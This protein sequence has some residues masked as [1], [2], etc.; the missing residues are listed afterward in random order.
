MMIRVMHGGSLPARM[1]IPD[2]D[3]PAD[4]S[5]EAAEVREVT[6]LAGQIHPDLAAPAAV[7]R[8]PIQF[9]GTE[10]YLAGEDAPFWNSFHPFLVL[11]RE[12]D[13]SLT[14]YTDDRNSQTAIKLQTNY[15]DVLHKQAALTTTG[16]QWPSGCTTSRLGAPSGNGAVEKTSGGIYYAALAISYGLFGRQNAI[17]VGIANSNFTALASPITPLG[18]PAVPSTLTSIDVNGD[19]KPDLIVVSANQNTGLATLSVFFGNGD[20]TYQQPRADYATQLITGSVTVADVNNDSHPDLIMVGSPASGNPASPALQVFLNDTH[21]A[22][23][24][25]INGPAIPGLEQVAVVAKFNS[26]ANPDIA[27]NGGYILLGDGTGHFTLKSGIQFSAADSLIAGDLNHD[28]KIDI[29]TISGFHYMVGIFLGNNDGTFTAGQQYASI[30]G[31]FN[32]GMSDLDGDGNQDLIAGFSDPNG[33]GPGSGS[34]S[35]VYF[36]LGRGDGTFAGAPLYTT[37]NSN[38]AMTGPS[39]ALADLDGDTK[40]DLITTTSAA[41][42]LSLFTLL[43]KGDGSFTPAT[44]PPINAFNVSI[45]PPLVVAGDL[46]GNTKNDVIVGITTQNSP[47]QGELVVFLGNGNDTF[48]TEKDTSLSSGIGAMILGDFNNDKKPDLI[49][50]GVVSIDQQNS[51][52]AG[53]LFFLAGAGTGSF[54]APTSIANP[55]NAAALASFDFDGDQNLD[56]VVGD[57]GSTNSNA[58][59]A[60]SVKVYLGNGNGSFQAPKTLNAPVFAQAI[61]TADVN[62]DSN[63]DIVVLSAPNFSG[64][65]PFV[66][67]VYVFMG[68]GHGSFGSAIT[69]TLDEFATGLQVGDLNADGFPDLA[70]TSCCGFA[71]SEVWSGNGDGTFNGPNELP[72]GLS[73]SFPVLANLNGDSKPD[74]LVGLGKGIMS[75]VNISATGI[76]TPIQAGSTPTATATP[77]RTPTATA[78]K[79]ATATAT[80][81]A[82]ATA[83]VV[84]TA[85]PTSTPAP[86]K[87]A[88]RT[89]TPIGTPTKTA[90]PTPS[91]APTT[92][93]LIAAPGK[94]NFGKVDATGTS[95]LKKIKLSNKG[96]AAANISNISASAPFVIASS[97]NTC[98]GHSIPPKKTCTFE[99]EF[100]PALVSEVTN[101]SLNVIYNG[102]SPTVTLTGDAIAAT[103]KAPRAGS[104]PAQAA[105]TVG[106]VKNLAFSNSSAVALVLGTATRSGADADSLQIASDTCSGHTLAPKAKCIVGVRFA[107]PADAS[108][109]QTATLAL[110]FTYGA[111]GGGVSINLAVKLKPPKK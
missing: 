14:V 92:T 36:L 109:T 8:P 67:T 89:A 5:D 31:A 21:G 55:L 35:Y 85:T 6:R 100:E 19:S 105:G 101:G 64:N 87:T 103:L 84:R 27:T 51:P 76:P 39:F 58:P 77:V 82:T 94:S 3:R 17:S 61:A 4:S 50:G 80:K 62:N 111:N 93:T 46:T 69:T 98:T 23:G 68:D 33:F 22:F 73:S 47:G 95:K 54:A 29:A 79:T 108:G 59:V 28:N 57:G 40:P 52:T 66:S 9:L 16:D 97:A 107:P 2:R 49:A 26:D 15:Q 18:V 48:G 44:T 43:G 20:G 12:S 91:S 1:W 53:N 24:L 110:G 86:T 75:M 78:T 60:G 83:T 71:N 104:F 7:L 11:R 38:G 88:T 42:K 74:L 81:T 32:I 56:L 34:A 65:Q 41:G 99:V 90:T 37:P 96:S 45:H 30:Y 63:E 70:V 10:S 106:R 72:I 25:P 13:C 102:A